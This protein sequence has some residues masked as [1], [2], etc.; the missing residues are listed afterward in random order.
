MALI[1]TKTKK[2]KENGGALNYFILVP[3]FDI[4]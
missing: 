3:T 4:G 2:E 1:F